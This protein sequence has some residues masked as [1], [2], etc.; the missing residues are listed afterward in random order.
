MTPDTCP[1]CG[2]PLDGQNG[3]ACGTFQSFD[4][5]RWWPVQS[6]ECARYVRTRISQLKNDRA[7]GDA[8]QA[9]KREGVVEMVRELSDSLDVVPVWRRTQI[10]VGSSGEGA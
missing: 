8:L 2:A 5:V 6:P 3:W 7:L 10:P 4:R 9:L 1:H